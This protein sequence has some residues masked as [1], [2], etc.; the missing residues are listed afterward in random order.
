MKPDVGV[1]IVA[2][3]KG[4]RAGGSELKQ[5]RWVAGKPM[6]LHSVHAFQERTDVGM[7]VVV[8]PHAHV[9]DPPVW[10]F[11]SDTERLLLSVGGRERIDSVRNGLE[12]LP[13][14]LGI[15]V[16]H[17][18]ARPL[19][20]AKMID[21][22]ITQARNGNAAAP[23]IPVV[24]TLKRV[25]DSGRIIDTVERTG[26]MRIQT[27]QAFPRDM[28]MEAHQ[29]AIAEGVTATDDAALCERLGM[30]VMVVPGNELAMKITSEEDFARAEAM[31]ILRG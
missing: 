30:K 13:N 28:L 7:V 25:D 27:P 3:G 23:G 16:V 20:T 5:F 11:Q 26:V 6:L 12:D 10:L 18:A 4:S 9:G 29:K 17:D 2:G 22:V 31:S 1:V 14:D 21:D 24:D 15:I 19:V 8:L